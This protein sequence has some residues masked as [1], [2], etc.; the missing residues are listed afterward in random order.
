MPRLL[1]LT[2]LLGLLLA[3]PASARTPTVPRDWLGVVVDGPMTDRSADRGGEWDL[4]ADSGA[5]SVRAAFY[6]YAAQ[7]SGPGAMD[8]TA[9]DAVVL[10]AARRGLRVLP[11]VHGTPGWAAE[12]P[13]DAGSRPRDLAAF[14]AYLR[15]LVGRYGPSGSLWAEH[16]EVARRPIRAWQIWNEPN[17]TRYWAEQ[18]FARAYVRTL[19]V[20][21]AALRGADRG[22]RVI[23]AGLPNRSWIGLR[24]VYRAGGRRAFDA[25]ALHPYTGRPSNVV[26]LV[27]YARRVMKRYGDRRKPVWITELS[28]PAAEGK[29]DG[30]AG[31]ETDDRGQARRLRDGL[32]LLAKARRKL[33][34]QRVF[35]YTWLSVE[36][37]ENSFAWSGLRRIRD[38]Q[39]V[40]APALRAFRTTAARLRD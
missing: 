2:L 5:T 12:T 36:G 16:P 6:W 31:F 25:V 18:P 30:T 24:S 20:A 11:V 9:Y 8:F 14:A 35:W 38:G 22:A 15:A 32:R 13:G 23:L 29:V 7:P 26:R 27:E 37:G 39:V 4:L 21:R 40:S 17:I 1:L 19:R 34:I 3:A 28:W 10:D 33:R